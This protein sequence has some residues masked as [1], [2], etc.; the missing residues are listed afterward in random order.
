[1]IQSSLFPCY[2]HR[3]H[4]DTEWTRWDF[5]TNGQFW[6]NP[7]RH[8]VEWCFEREGEMDTEAEEEEESLGL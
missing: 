6:S 8:I 7:I 2:H 5:L 3:Q 4:D 1:M